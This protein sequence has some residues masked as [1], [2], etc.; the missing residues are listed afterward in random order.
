MKFIS[1]YTKAL[2]RL[3]VF[4]KDISRG[5]DNTSIHTH[6]EEK[7]RVSEELEAV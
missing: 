3:L 1:R 7:A 5:V 4:G 6:L 2:I